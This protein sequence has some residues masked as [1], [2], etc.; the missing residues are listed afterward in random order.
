MQKPESKFVDAGGIKTHYIEAGQGE[1]VV[2]IHGGGAGADGWGNWSKTMPIIAAER[3]VIAMDML[4]FGQTAKP[5]GSFEYTQ[6]ARNK[7]LVDFLDALHV[8]NAAMVGNSMGGATV[9]A[10]AV[11]RPDLIGKIVLMGS[12]GLVHT[13]WRGDP[14]RPQI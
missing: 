9:I 8:K 7:H 3:R 12:A 14:V 11:R 13:S 4:G 2:L 6:E 10:A 1:P 5:N